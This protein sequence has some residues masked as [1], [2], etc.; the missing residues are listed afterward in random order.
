M[1][2][3]FHKT[4]RVQIEKTLIEEKDFKYLMDS[5]DYKLFKRNICIHQTRLKAVIRDL[6]DLLSNLQILEKDDAD[7]ESG[8][9]K[10]S[11]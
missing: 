9:K 6:D 11:I 3:D 4:G 5:I 7:E 2:E 8:E 1:I 10:R